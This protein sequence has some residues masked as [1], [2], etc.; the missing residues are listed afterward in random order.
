MGRIYTPHGAVDTPG[1]VPVATNGAIKGMEFRTLDG[2]RDRDDTRREGGDED[3][4]GGPSDGGSTTGRSSGR[5]GQL[6]FCNT[7]HLMIHPG[8]EVIGNAGGI[9]E[10]TGRRDGG[11]FITDSGGFQVFSLQHGSVQDDRNSEGF[12]GEGDGRVRPSSE[13]K[14]ARERGAK[15]AGWREGASGPDA[16]KVTEEGVSF[17]SYRDG[18]KILLTPEGTV[19]A[20]KLIGADIIVPL[21]ELPPHHID[22]PGLEESVE[23]SH[24]WEARSLMEHLGDVRDQ[25]MYAVVHGGTDRELRA[26]SVRYLTSLPFDGYAIGGSL[27]NDR[28]G[29]RELL[30]WTMPLFSDGDDNDERGRVESKPR[31]LLGIGDEESVRFGSAMGVDTFDSCYP[32]RL[33]R[34]GTLL[35]RSEGLIRIKRAKHARS[36]GM[37]IDEGCQ[38]RTCRHYDR[39]YLCHLFKANEP[40]G[41]MLGVEH[42]LHYMAQLMTGIREDILEGKI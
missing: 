37:P 21:D 19:R 30:R 10:F 33:G 20:Q 42:N 31:H 40:L 18:S 36:Y 39:A 24:R 12:G 1:F 11:P 9:H 8:A 34:H 6:V 28:E 2:D 4:A 26:R 5:R 27:G 16:V 23:R 7:Y 22:R 29:L 25:A 15:R 14:R 13:L 17:R 41:V 32:T 38:C 3:G 35:T